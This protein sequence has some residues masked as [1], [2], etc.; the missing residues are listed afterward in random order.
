[1]LRMPKTI[2]Q[3]VAKYLLFVLLPMFLNAQS[4]SSKQ[5]NGLADR[6]Y[7]LQQLDEIS[8][9][10]LYNLANDSLKVNMPIILSK[11]IDNVENRT[12]AA[13]LEAFART[14]S[15]IAPWLNLEGGSDS[16]VKL[17]NLYRAWVLKATANAVNPSAKDYME[18]NKGGQP[19]VDASYL[20][21]AFLRCPWLWEHLND[22]TKKQVVDA[23]KLTR[24]VTPPFQNWILFTGMIE[25]FL[26]QY[27]QDW[28]AVRIEYGIRQF[29]QWYVGDGVY[30]DGPPYEWDYYNSYVIHPY[31]AKITE[32]INAKYGTYKW[33]TDKLKVRNE[34]YAIIQERLIAADGSYPATGRSIVYRGAA[35]H[36]LADMSMRKKLPT[37]LKPAQVR[38]ALTSVLKRTMDCPNTYTK[39][40]WLNIGLCGS[41]PDLADW[42]NTT[43]SL[44]ICTNILLP[45]GLPETD[46]FW[47][48]PPLKF[49]A[50]KIWNGEDVKGDHGIQ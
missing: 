24:K 45:L 21:L 46:E 27:N 4:S 6:Q 49:T 41:Q 13:Y 14:L 8:R 30:S 29:E 44:Y 20:A 16:E 1:M 10:V 48:T 39:D 47:A 40:G 43:G 18:W 36:H 23:F 22:A 33:L 3:S 17:R 42:Y 11:R 7:W 5:V 2:I 26:C 19:L 31:L 34:R 28:D 38:C 25:T 35:F 37:E 12:R 9:P 15:G 50:Q 32:V